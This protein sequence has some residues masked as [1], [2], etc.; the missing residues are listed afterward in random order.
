MTPRLA[1]PALL[2]ALAAAP[3]AA[4]DAPPSL[5]A[6]LERPPP[7]AAAASAFAGERRR[8][9]MRTAAVAWGSRAGLARRGWEIAGITERHA[10]QLS[11]VFRFRGLML[12]RGGFLV[13]PPVVAATSR[14]LR[15]E[16]DRAAHARRVVR[17]LAPARIVPAPPHWRDFLTRS[18][19]DPS[20]PAAVLFPRTAA[21]TRLWRG[22]IA[23]GWAAG[24]ELA[25]D[26]FAADL[27]RLAAAFEGMLLWRRF[28]SARMVSGPTVDV[29]VADVAGDG[30]SMRIAE[31]VAALTE[32]ARLV[33]RPSEWL[34]VPAE[35]AR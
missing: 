7:P 16:G 4:R 28:R 30:T 25:D 15:V 26:V 10:P 3:A 33:A 9:A 19:A 27:D 17:I 8:A 22:W 13:A 23:E 34:P 31:T 5:D 2:A 12:R 1:V 24:R 11:A 29:T 35:T 21:E 14:V 32:P 6:L 18:W 20:P